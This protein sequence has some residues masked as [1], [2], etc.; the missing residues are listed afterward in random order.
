M[1]IILK[2][3]RVW[4]LDYMGDTM[5]YTH[6]LDICFEVTTG[7]CEPFDLSDEVI[8]AALK[9]RVKT[10]EDFGI[11]GEAVGHCDTYEPL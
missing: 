2:L 6:V 11:V 9:A 10:I 7:E 3:A 5:K 4:F 1:G 8:L